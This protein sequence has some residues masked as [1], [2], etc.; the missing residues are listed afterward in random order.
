MTVKRL[1]FT[2]I[3]VA[4][5]S[6]AAQAQYT[7]DAL[8]FSQEND[9]GTARFKSMGS[10]QTSLG[11]D[12]SSVSGNPAGLGFFNTSDASVSF[13]YLN[14]KNK[15]TYFGNKNSAS[16][17]RFTL[18]NGAIVFNFPSISQGGNVQKGI[19][20]FNVGFA[21]NQIQDYEN[22]LY[23]E[24]QNPDN[25]IVHSFADRM[26]DDLSPQGELGSFAKE[27]INKTFIVEQFPN[28][29][30]D[31]FFPTVVEKGSIQ[32][33]NIA[34]RGSKSE[35]T[36]SFGAN[37]SN[38]FYFGASIGLTSLRYETGN[39][40]TEL[41][42]IKTADE[43]ALDNPNSHFTDPNN[44]NEFLR[45]GQEYDL[46]SNYYQRTEGSGANF[47][48]GFIYKI[49]PTLNLGFTA[50]TPTW[51]SISDLT[52]ER[53]DVEYSG[54]LPSDLPEIQVS[55]TDYTMQSPFKFSLGISKILSRGL[56]TADVDYTDFSTIR[57]YQNNVVRSNDILYNNSKK[58][59]QETYQAAFNARLGG[60]LLIDKTFKGR[61]GFNYAGN[62]YKNADYENLTYTAGLGAR[63]NN[64]FYIDVAVLH[65]RMSFS[66]NPYVIAEQ[67]WN[68]Q[69]PIADVKNNRTNVV[70]TIGTKF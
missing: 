53:I 61:L 10:A 21:Y 29:K 43:I 24:G 49:D 64:F 36:I 15:S 50:K 12:L 18:D 63:I 48:L 8:I 9:G 60:E 45:T 44:T 23:Y 51:T 17:D 1:L 66:E 2:G 5:L 62:P 11:G 70:L 59:V 35:S 46:Y 54:G 3:I 41:G 4:G 38:K 39:L 52:E 30:D 47:K 34:E 14:N 68:S 27:M 37:V 32:S 13:N 26:F 33:N 25:S 16:K 58:S 65:N 56:I 28:V 7:R 6:H 69:S 40:F 31:G 20:N 57:L 55:N 22:H 19:L 67:F 42:T